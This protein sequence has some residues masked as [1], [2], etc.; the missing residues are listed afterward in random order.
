MK[1]ISDTQVSLFKAF[2]ES[3]DSF[4]I[5]G[6]KEPDGDC[7]SSSLGTAAIL[8]SF[9]KT[10]QLL[11]AG[12]FKRPELKEYE[13]RFAKQIVPRR[14]AQNERKPALVIVDCSETER[15]G[16]ILPPDDI[17]DDFSKYDVFIID[18]HKTSEDASGNSI[19]EPT[20]PATACLVQQLYEKLVGTP[21][22]ETAK[23][24]FF[25]LATDT[26][27]FRF[28]G[29]ESAEVFHA[30]ARLVEAGADPRLIYEH[31]QGGKP[32]NTRKLLGIMLSRAEQKF[33]GKLLITYETME[34]T[35]R[36]G[37]EGRDSDSLYQLLSAVDGVQAVVFVRQ[38]TERS[39]TIGLRSKD[40]IDVSAIAAT[41]GGG[42]HKNAAGC[43]T[44]GTLDVIIPK[45]LQEFTKYF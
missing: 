28:L 8:D 3:H 23:L 6:H 20:A 41:F 4:V 38:E 9:K 36:Y 22:A 32:Y 10:Y 31:M 16:D 7:I 29:N 40:A 27:Y 42:G 26:G 5:A 24:L 18:H 25:G 39:C 17:S 1:I 30:A 14:T 21:D 35:R 43:S 44:P 34:D 15:L 19:I 33:G 11:S 13:K 2:V 37:M 12:P 45:I